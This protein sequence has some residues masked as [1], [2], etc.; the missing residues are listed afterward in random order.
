[1]KIRTVR[2][3]G[4]GSHAVLVAVTG[5]KEPLPTTIDEGEGY[6]RDAKDKVPVSEVIWEEAPESKYHSLFC[7]GFNVMVLKVGARDCWSHEGRPTIGL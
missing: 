1:V 3:K 5:S 4:L 2:E 7:G 6:G